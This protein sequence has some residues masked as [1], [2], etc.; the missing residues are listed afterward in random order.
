VN[1]FFKSDTGVK[2]TTTQLYEFW[3]STFKADPEWLVTRV[4]TVPKSGLAVVTVIIALKRRASSN[5]ES[6]WWIISTLI[7]II[8]LIAFIKLA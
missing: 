5:P 1:N 6:F 4:Q 8:P 3:G 2:V 7:L